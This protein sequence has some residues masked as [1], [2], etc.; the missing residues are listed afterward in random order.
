MS[1]CGFA[2]LHFGS[3]MCQLE[4]EA[5]NSS[6]PLTG[7]FELTPRCNMDCRMC[8]VHLKPDQIPSVGRE[9][10]ADEWIGLAL[11]AREM[12]MLQLTLTGG[13][14][15]VRSDFR[16]IYEALSD[17]GFLIQIFTNGYALD[18]ETVDWLAARPPFALRFTLYGFSDETYERVC[19]VKNGFTR[20]MGAIERVHKAGI[21]VYIVSTITKDNE[22][23]LQAIADFCYSNGFAFTCTTKLIYPVRGAVADVESQQIEL[24]LPDEETLS[25]LR[26]SEDRPYPRQPVTDL[27]NACSN[28]RKGFWITWNGNMQLC[29]FLTEPARSV[30]EE[31]FESAWHGL[32][33]DLDQLKQ[34]DECLNCKYER[35]CRRCY[36]MHYAE[37]GRC[38]LPAR[39]VCRTAQFMYSVYGQDN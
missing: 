9:L 34:P 21:T 13:E 28:Y 24:T 2:D 38:D 16:R 33:Q 8:Y 7:V 6:I 22:C 3:Y 5:Y 29:T 23:D 1:I 36:G 15:F 11:K 12:G 26:S 30:L 20:V 37:T 31:D 35:Y 27:L 10:T 39:S 4:Q 32:L 14:V 25:S 17:M 19:G 18:Q